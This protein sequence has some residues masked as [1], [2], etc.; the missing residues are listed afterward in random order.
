MSVLV[1]IFVWLIIAYTLF[2]RDFKLFTYFVAHK[3]KIIASFN[4]Q[5]MKL[6]LNLGRLACL[7]MI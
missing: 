5:L 4:M 2:I 7:V 6:Y 3:S 1:N